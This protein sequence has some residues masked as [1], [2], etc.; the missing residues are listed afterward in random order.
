VNSIVSKPCTICPFDQIDF[1]SADE[2]APAASFYGRRAVVSGFDCRRCRSTVM[3]MI[4]ATFL[5]GGG[6][7]GLP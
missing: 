4:V 5:E 3:A 6:A 7:G 1:G 2:D